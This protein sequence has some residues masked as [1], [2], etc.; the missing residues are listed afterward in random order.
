MSLSFKLVLSEYPLHTNRKRNEG[1]TEKTW[2]IKRFS[3]VAGGLTAPDGIAT[4]ADLK[5]LPDTVE[6]SGNWA[7]QVGHRVCTIKSRAGGL[8]WLANLLVPSLVQHTFSLVPIKILIRV[9]GKLEVGVLI[10][11]SFLVLQY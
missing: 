4:F 7:V 6:Q 5:A 8:R 2:L 10:H 11:V 3:P 1:T 9:S